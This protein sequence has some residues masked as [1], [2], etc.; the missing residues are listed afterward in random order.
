MYASL[1]KWSVSSDDPLY[2]LYFI[3]CYTNDKNEWYND[4]KHILV[5]KD[6]INFFEIRYHICL[7]EHFKEK[8]L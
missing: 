3:K 5:E 4:P 6:I 7:F 8:D 1:W 2:Y